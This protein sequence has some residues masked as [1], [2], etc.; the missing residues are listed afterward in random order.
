MQ[1][2]G[3][4]AER[5]ETMSIPATIPLSD[6]EPIECL[7]HFAQIHETFRKA[8]IDALAVLHGIEV[9]WTG[10]SDD[11]CFSLSLCVSSST[12][13]LYSAIH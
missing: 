1:K 5:K 9:V 2:E 4:E 6:D 13:S 10:Y 11:V 3:E 12:S 8:E 7:I